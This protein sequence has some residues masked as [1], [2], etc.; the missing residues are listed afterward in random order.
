MGFSRQ[1]CW[2][3]LPFLSPGGLPN[4]GIKPGSPALQADAL[5][6]EPPGKPVKWGHRVSPNPYD[7]CPYKRRKMPCDNGSGCCCS[8]SKL[9]PTLFHPLDCTRQVSLSSTISW[10]LL[11]LMSIELVMLSNHLILCWRLLVLPS[12]PASEYFP[13][14]QHFT[15]GGQSIGASASA[16]FLPINIQ[17]WFPLGLTSL[18]SLQSKGLS[19]VSSSTTVQKH[20]FFGP[21]PSLWTNS[22]IQKN[23]SF[24]Y[25]DLLSAKRCL[26][27]LT[28]CSCEYMFVIAFLP[29]SKHLWISWLQ[30]TVIL[31]LKKIKSATVSTFSPSICHEVMGPDA[32]ILVFCM[33]TFRSAFSLFFHPHQEAL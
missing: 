11:K 32:M 2:S 14:S 28:C 27:F 7:W 9:C 30:S 1:E 26:C 5:P 23:H 12:F 22:H 6:S 15:S 24:G 19:R 33:L 16:P 4:P 31:E 10:S 3:V 25:R 18:I 21:Q 20:Q 8:V 29:S 13:V 17:S